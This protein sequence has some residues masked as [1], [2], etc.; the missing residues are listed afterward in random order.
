MQSK[1][2]KPK[3]LVVFDLDSTLFDVSPRTLQILHDFASTPKAQSFSSH[4]C[5]KLKE[6][7]SLPSVY[8]LKELTLHFNLGEV[9]PEFYHAL[10]QYW[11][12]EFFSNKLLHLDRPEDGAIDF[13]HEVFAKG[14]NIIYLTGR[15]EERMGLGT[16][17][18]LKNFGFPLDAEKAHVELKP[19]R[20]LDDALFKRDFL[21]EMHALTDFVPGPVWFIENEPANI[22]AVREGLP[23]VNVIFFDSIHAGTH[24]V[25]A[26]LPHI[27]NFL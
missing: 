25:P 21:I 1:F 27:K 14:S 18:V 4:A 16:R 3:G 2:D 6:V 23:H 5:K 11:R 8:H 15:D 9:P 19:H 26:D 10:F 22:V 12:E 17:N 7:N 13:C 24:P 20:S